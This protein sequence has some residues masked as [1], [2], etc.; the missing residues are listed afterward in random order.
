MPRN[1]NQSQFGF[2]VVELLVVFLILVTLMSVGIINWNR[3]TPNRSLKIAQN[4]MITNLRKVQSYAISSRN[5]TDGLP[6]SYYI[7]QLNRNESA[8]QLSALGP[9]GEYTL[10]KSLENLNLPSALVISDLFLYNPGDIV[11]ASHECVQ[12]IISVIYGEMYFRTPVQ[13]SDC[14][15]SNWI[16]GVRDVVRRPPDLAQLSR[17]D[18]DIIFT[19]VNSNTSRSVT[20]NGV[21]GRIQEF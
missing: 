17:G 6:A 14:L 5:I 4:E 3:Q 13:S 21:T 16:E 8:Y 19:H 20:V 2:T 11:V 9:G 7:L 12:I 15:S 10:V 18:L 1:Q